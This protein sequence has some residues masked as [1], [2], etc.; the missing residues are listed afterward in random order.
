MSVCF[1]MSLRLFI[2]WSI[3]AD[4]STCAHS[5]IL[6]SELPF[7]L[8]FYD[9]Y[10]ILAA[11]SINILVDFLS[12]QFQFHQKPNCNETKKTQFQTNNLLKKIKRHIND[13]HVY[14]A[15]K[16]HNYLVHMSAYKTQPYSSDAKYSMMLRILV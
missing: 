15:V 13:N 8:L 9:D 16:L 4:H 3:G 12:N 10:L 2:Q 11:L 7:F 6:H 1:V 14:N 5:I